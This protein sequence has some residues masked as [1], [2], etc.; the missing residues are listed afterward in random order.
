[1]AILVWHYL[2]HKKEEGL[3]NLQ[4]PSLGFERGCMMALGYGETGKGKSLKKLLAG[5]VDMKKNTVNGEAVP[6]RKTKG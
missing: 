1:M 6:V 2:I 5:D 3:G 4:P